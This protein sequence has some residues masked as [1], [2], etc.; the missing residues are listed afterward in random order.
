MA[1]SAFSLLTTSPTL[2][3]RFT[4]FSS[5]D[6]TCAA[7]DR[8]LPSQ[9]SLKFKTALKIV[10]VSNGR[11]TV[12]LFDRAPLVRRSWQDEQV[13]VPSADRRG[14]ENRRSPSE[15]LSGSAS[16]G[17]G[18]GLIGSWSAT[19]SSCNSSDGA[20]ANVVAAIR[21]ATHGRMMP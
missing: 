7:G 20:C 14:S 3:R 11:D 21:T 12:P 18:I 9:F 15:S 16:G 1:G 10:G 4:E 17:G 13:S 19:G 8:I 5:D 2:V 6:T